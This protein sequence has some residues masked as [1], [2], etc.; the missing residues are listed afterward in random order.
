MWNCKQSPETGGF[1]PPA[2]S[3]CGIPRLVSSRPQHRIWAADGT[4]SL[5]KQL[6]VNVWERNWSS[7]KC[8]RGSLYLSKEQSFSTGADKLKLNMFRRRFKAGLFWMLC[9]WSKFYSVILY[10]AAVV[11]QLQANSLTWGDQ[12]SVQSDFS[13]TSVWIRFSLHVQQTRKDPSS[14]WPLLSII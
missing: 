8:C 7:K 6:P 12:S 5:T 11:K 14:C 13:I 4:F 2:S 9:F 3:R 1:F 10:F